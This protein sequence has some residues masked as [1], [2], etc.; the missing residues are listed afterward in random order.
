AEALARGSKEDQDR[1]A[2]I[3]AWIASDAPDPAAFR[4]YCKAFLT[5]KGEPRKR[6][7]T[8]AVAAENPDLPDFLQEECE[9]LLAVRERL[10]LVEVAENTE[11]LLVFGLA[12]LASYEQEK[13]R[14][15]ALDYDDLIL[16]T[17][18]L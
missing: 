2:L 14:Q 6:L 12:A 9:R 4:A 18:A 3:R 16:T 7:A 5:D 1:A 11:A 13:R 10:A 17:L 8:K 15:V